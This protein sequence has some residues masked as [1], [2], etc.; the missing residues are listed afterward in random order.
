MLSGCLRWIVRPIGFW[1]GLA[2]ILLLGHSAC[3]AQQT[4]NVLLRMEAGRGFFS[5]PPYEKLCWEKLFV[6]PGDVARYF[7]VPIWKHPETLVSI[8]RSRQ[9][10]GSLPGNYWVTVTRP[11]RRM[12]RLFDDPNA[13]PSQAKAI[14][15]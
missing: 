2:A 9:R 4:D 11:T 8:H 6:T 1:A 5:N 3:S 7:F 15:V 13:H 12:D 10:A 14:T